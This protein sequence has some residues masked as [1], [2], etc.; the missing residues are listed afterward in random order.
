MPCVVAALLSRAVAVQPLM[1]IDKIDIIAIGNA[2][3]VLLRQD[4]FIATDFGLAGDFG[5]GD[6][7]FGELVNNCD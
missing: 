3:A 1:T 6:F 2:L 7:G 4:E 5:F